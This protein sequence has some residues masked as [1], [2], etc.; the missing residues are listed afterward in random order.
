MTVHAAAAVQRFGISPKI[1]LLSHSNFG[2]HRH[3]AALK[4][5]EA[6]RLLH[7]N[8][9]DLEVEGEMHADAALSEEIRNRI[10]PNSK[11]KGAANLLIMPTLD[12][13]N[14]SFNLLKVMAEGLSVGPLLLGTACPAHIATPSITARGVINLCAIAAVDAQSR[15][16]VPLTDKAGAASE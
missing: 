3:P 16:P 14:I 5:R 9:P 15:A 2:S 11:L 4:M 10:F 1:A 7:E 6:V 12:A 13:A 8:Y